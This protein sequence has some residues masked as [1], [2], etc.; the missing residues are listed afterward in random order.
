[1]ID[2]ENIALEVDVW[3]TIEEQLNTGIE[4]VL[5]LHFLFENGK[6]EINIR[7]P[8]DSEINTKLIVLDEDESFKLVS[9]LGDR[10][11]FRWA[12]LVRLLFYLNPGD[13]PHFIAHYFPYVNDPSTLNGKKSRMNPITID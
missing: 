11:N 12:N 9:A 13:I 10:F 1:M 6:S 5:S 2:S 4:N 7:H 3:E 8:K